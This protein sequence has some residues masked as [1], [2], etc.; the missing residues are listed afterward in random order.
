MVTGEKVEFAGGGVVVEGADVVPAEGALA[1][2]GPVG[3]GSTFSLT[4]VEIL[5]PASVGRLEGDDDGGEVT[6]LVA[7]KPTR[8]PFRRR[9]AAAIFWRSGSVDIVVGEFLAENVLRT[10]QLGAGTVEID[11][12]FLLL[13]RGKGGDPFLGENDVGV[14]FAKHPPGS[15]N[16][17][18]LGGFE[19]AEP[20]D[21]GVGGGSGSGV[22]P[23]VVAGG[24]FFFRVTPVIPAL[25]PNGV[26][27]A[28]FEKV[29]G[30]VGTPGAT[31]VDFYIGFRGDAAVRENV[32]EFFILTGGSGSDVAVVAAVD[33]AL[34]EVGGGIAK[35]EIDAA[36]DFALIKK[37]ALATDEEGVLPT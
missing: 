34:L 31:E 1:L 4:V 19:W 8:V 24:F 2:G 35:D 37:L 7:A 28:A 10:I 13:L 26:G 9:G 23:F 32:A 22:L 15:L 29:D 18:S 11:L 21:A 6:G 14:P 12:P 27:E 25:R 20:A 17:P 30:G 3:A 33:V 16:A 5:G 36:G